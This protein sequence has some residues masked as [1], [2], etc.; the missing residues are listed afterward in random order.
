MIKKEHRIYVKVQANVTRDRNTLMGW[1]KGRIPSEM[2]AIYLKNSNNWKEL[3]AEE[4][5][6]IAHWLG[7]V[8]V[9]EKRIKN[10]NITEFVSNS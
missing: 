6:E 9:G 5:V 2:A 4:F 1:E 7:Y 10:G 8:R 3:S